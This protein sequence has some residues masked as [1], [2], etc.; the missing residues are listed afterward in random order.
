M[1]LLTHKTK[2]IKI[3]I[4]TDGQRVIIYY[5]D[6]AI[7]ITV[8]SQA[9]HLFRTLASISYDTLYSNKVTCV[10]LGLSPNDTR[11]Y[12]S[13]DL[14]GHVRKK[15]SELIDCLCQNDGFNYY[16]KEC[17]KNKDH[18]KK[19]DICQGN[20]D[21]ILELIKQVDGGYQLHDT[22]EVSESHK[23]KI[24]STFND[25]ADVIEKTIRLQAEIKS[26]I[27]RDE[28]IDGKMRKAK[29]LEVSS[30]T[31]TIKKHKNDFDKIYD[32]LLEATQLQPNEQNYLHIE[33]E[34]DKIHKYIEMSQYEDADTK[35]DVW[36]RLFKSELRVKYTELETFYMAMP[37]IN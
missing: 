29:R 27:I 21:N 36:R 4:D 16:K 8:P 35:D 12:K 26:F 24:K 25:L 15:K 5:S 10:D 30:Y 7:S 33:N 18:C 2:N 13:G 6:K 17:K 37:S 19:R 1:L 20:N 22:W 11:L 28:N 9:L 32:Q 14:S 31:E 3:G 34:L 23:K